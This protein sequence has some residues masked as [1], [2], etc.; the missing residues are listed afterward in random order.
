M[1]VRAHAGAIHV[2]RLPIEV[3]RRIRLRLEGG[4]DAIPA[5]DLAPTIAA[6]RDGRPRAIALGQI[7]PGRT[8]A[9]DPQDAVQDAA[10]IVV[11]AAGPRPLRGE[12]GRQ[13]LLLPIRQLITLHVS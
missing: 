10:M 7:A 9:M 13:T 1:L 4:E 8:R 11:R 5:P 2:M 3:A 12:Q 6:G